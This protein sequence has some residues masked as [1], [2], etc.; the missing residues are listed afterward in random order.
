MKQ[1]HENSSKRRRAAK[2][3]RAVR[4]KRILKGL[5]NGILAAVVLSVIL[6]ACGLFFTSRDAADVHPTA[7]P[8]AGAPEQTPSPSRAPDPTATAA[9]T[10]TVAPTVTPEPTPA[11]R[12]ARFRVTGDLMASESIL[13]YA[14]SAAGGDGYDFSPMFALVQD[15]LEN[16]DYTMGNLE[17]TIGRYKELEYSGYPMFN[18]PESYLAALQGAGYDFLT[19]A[20]NH[21]LDRYFDGMKNT[22]DNVERQGFDFC[23]AYRT[24]QER[25]S[26]K[27]V[28]INGIRFGFLSYTQDTNGME[29]YCDAAA[30]EFG[31]PY[32]FRSDFSAD[33]AR[34]RRAGAEV[35][36]VFPHWGEE[37][38]RQPDATERQYAQKLAEAG[39]DI[40]LAS[41][42]HVLQKT[43]TLTVTDGDG[44]ERS[45]F[46]AYSLGNFVATQERPYTDTGV[47]LDF[48][49]QE[50]SDGT[51]IVTDAGCIPTYCWRH[52]GTL[53]VVP[54]SQYLDQRPEGMSDSA[55]KRMRAS[56]DETLQLFGDTLTVLTK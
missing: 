24:A 22:V 44:S 35:V 25:E 11:L 33:I 45:V 26:A 48:T 15:A 21:M 2:R 56:Y 12:S 29:G 7:H 19:L 9:P 37:Y 50:Q 31:V 1:P 14:A 3:R 43:D 4:R 10:V 32:L 20:N 51:F 36:I 41:H 13:K 5:L 18:T 49:V 30:T 16:A 54:S 23:G 38:G 40:I 27:I 55:Y 52:D 39:A 17:T 28:E 46:V 53:A 8:T 42:P 47:I 6:L 34:L